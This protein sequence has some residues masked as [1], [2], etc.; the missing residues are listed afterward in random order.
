MLRCAGNLLVRGTW[1][2]WRPRSSGKWSCSFSSPAGSTASCLSVSATLWQNDLF[3][4]FRKFLL[5]SCR[6]DKWLRPKYGWAPAVM[7]ARGQWVRC[8]FLLWTKSKLVIQVSVGLGPPCL[9]YH[10]LF[11][12]RPSLVFLLPS[13]SSIPGCFPLPSGWGIH[14]GD[15]GECSGV[16]GS[17]EHPTDN[18]PPALGRVLL[19]GRFHPAEPR[20]WVC[21]C[22]TAAGNHRAIPLREPLLP[23]IW[24]SPCFLHY[25][26]VL[27]QLANISFAQS[28]IHSGVLTW[29]LLGSKLTKLYLTISKVHNTAAK[30]RTDK[31]STWNSSSM[32]IKSM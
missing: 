32:G 7:P 2:C 8:C 13:S 31:G 29:S 3:D 30:Y 5:G 20:V 16:S 27:V 15:P 24:S 26:C 4:I 9:L 22:M 18:L 10:T 11:S 12:Q 28:G 1:G 17:C 23:V 6:A 19:G 21:C 25:T 14:N